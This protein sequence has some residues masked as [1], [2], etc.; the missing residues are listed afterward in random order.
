[1]TCFHEIMIERQQANS[2]SDSF[3]SANF[4]FINYNPLKINNSVLP[5]HVAIFAYGYDTSQFN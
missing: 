5:S 3:I 2:A 4:A 1:M